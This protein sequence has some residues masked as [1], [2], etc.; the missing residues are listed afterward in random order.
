LRKKIKDD[1]Q[2]VEIKTDNVY[3]STDG[4][5]QLS[6]KEL[7]SLIQTLP[8]T[9]RTVFNLFVF[10]NYSH[11]EISEML[12]LKE[13]NCRWHLNDARSR[14]KEKLNYLTGK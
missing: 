6:Y 1:R 10:E 14:L 5:E 11:K 7:L 8:E 3:V 12:K 2:I 4:M 9:Q 13:N